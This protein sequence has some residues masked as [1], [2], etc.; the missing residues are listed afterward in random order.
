MSAA[1]EFEQNAI[2]AAKQL[3]QTAKLQWLSGFRRSGREQ[4]QQQ[5]LPTRKTEA[6]KY[7]PL[8]S[9]WEHGFLDSAAP[10]PVS[11]DALEALVH[12]P[13][14]D[15]IRLVFVNGHFMPAL[16]NQ[17][18]VNGLTISR[19][20]EADDEQ[21]SIIQQ[22]L[23]KIATHRKH[24]FGSLNDSLTDDGLL[25]HVARNQI[26][27]KPIHI[28]HLSSSQA[29]YH[30]VHAR[31]LV[32]L[33][34]SAAATVIEHFSSPQTEQK[35][36]TNA[37][38]EYQLGANAQLTHYR[39]QLEHE[40]ALHVGGVHVNQQKDSRF[41]SYQIGLGG[42]L[43]RNDLRVLLAEPGAE[44]EIKGVYL[45]RHK[46]HI[47]NQT[48]MEHIA[49]NCQ[50]DEVFRGIVGDSSRAVFNG[51]IH[52]HPGAQQ[53]S[54]D[55]SNK[56][57]LLSDKAEVDTKPELEIYADD[58]KCSHGATV[59]QM[60]PQ[61]L[62]YLQ[63]RGVSRDEAEFMLSYGFINELI[64]AMPHSQIRE[65]LKPRLSEFF[66]HAPEIASFEEE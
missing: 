64:E 2:A 35:A 45:T 10:E 8:H 63:S 57:L 7:T 53:T 5:P 59:G 3:E 28:V 47:D 34:E 36:L 22:H 42:E 4:F 46:Q 44:S 30:Q 49:P 41:R 11:T 40:S 48:C 32:V 58:V 52:I 33:E 16:S 14:L 15:T 29:Q 37:I 61:H 24:P 55:L 54:A 38:S 19:F 65:I 39:L 66:Q 23:G 62:F 18:A 50:S 60:D 25:V 1:T 56:N 27:D 21:Q 26:V 31:L 20:Q 51:R 9:V 17:E 13:E 43:K 12:I 6:W